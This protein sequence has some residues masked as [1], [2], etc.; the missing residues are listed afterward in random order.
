MKQKY[1]LY[2][3]LAN[4][5][6]GRGKY[7]ENYLDYA[8]IIKDKA[9]SILGDVKVL[10]FGSVIKGNYLPNSDIDILIISDNAPE[11]LFEEVKIKHEILKAFEN[12]PFEIH[13]APPKLYEN[14]Y[15]NFIKT[16][17]IDIE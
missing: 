4:T 7:F 14:W 11:N 3:S 10:V 8:K 13:L 9:Q 16:G 5:Y 2:K 1:N 12:H 17:Y 15:K 6:E